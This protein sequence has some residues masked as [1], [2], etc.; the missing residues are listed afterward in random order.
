MLVVA[1]LAVML[2][3]WL[4][5]CDADVSAAETGPRGYQVSSNPHLDVSA[6]TPTHILGNEGSFE[7]C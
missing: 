6:I 4:V 7:L 2:S 5:C 3:R 1:D